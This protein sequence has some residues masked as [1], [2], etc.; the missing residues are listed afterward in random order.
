M[1]NLLNAEFAMPVF[2]AENDPERLNPLD[3]Y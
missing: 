2:S 3:A 1:R